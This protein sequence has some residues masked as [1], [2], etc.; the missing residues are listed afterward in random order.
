MFFRHFP[1]FR[2]IHQV[3][4]S[5]PRGEWHRSFHSLSKLNVLLTPE[6]RHRCGHR[7]GLNLLKIAFLYAWVFLCS[8]QD[9]WRTLCR[10]SL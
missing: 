10:I 5:K 8:N 9:A 1:K 3:C 4:H 2:N 7:I 6:Q